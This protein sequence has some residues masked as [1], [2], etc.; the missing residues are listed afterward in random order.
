[1]RIIIVSLTQNAHR[2][3]QRNLLDY[4]SVLQNSY[5]KYEVTEAYWERY[6]YD[7]C[8][9]THNQ[10][11]DY[12]VPGTVGFTVVNNPPAIPK[13]DVLSTSDCKIIGTIYNCP[14]SCILRLSIVVRRL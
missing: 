12:A 3:P 11:R 13:W 9:I 8:S 1:M 6:P 10:P 7:Y 14:T 2:S 5:R 4:K